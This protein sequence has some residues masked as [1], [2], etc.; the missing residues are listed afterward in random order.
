MS[1]K[2]SQAKTKQKDQRGSS[3]YVLA[4]KQATGTRAKYFSPTP[5]VLHEAH[6]DLPR[7]RRPRELFASNATA[8][9]DLTHWR[10]SGLALESRSSGDGSFGFRD[11]SAV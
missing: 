10:R 8:R 9:S 4:P 6:L 11:A 7:A 3:A 2:L 5:M 1:L